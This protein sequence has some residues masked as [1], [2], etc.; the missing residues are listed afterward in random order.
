MDEPNGN[1]VFLPPGI[2][3]KLKSTPEFPVP[4]CTSRLLAQSKKYQLEPRNKLLPLKSKASYLATSKRMNIWC[5][6]TSLWLIPLVD[7]LLGM[8]KSLLLLSLIDA[9]FTM[10]PLPVLFGLIIRYPQD[11]ATNIRKE[12]FKTMD[13]GSSTC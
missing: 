4:V 7:C 1:K 12:A 10:M 5:L 6:H 2:R 11:P 13:L 9:P 3:N 8:G